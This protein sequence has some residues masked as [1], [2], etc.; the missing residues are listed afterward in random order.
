[1]KSTLLRRLRR[2]AKRNIYPATFNGMIVIIQKDFGDRYFRT[3]FRGWSV[4]STN[5]ENYNE[6]N[7]AKELKIARNYYIKGK[8]KAL[9]NQEILN[10]LNE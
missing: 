7:L 3:E 5:A 10:K 6:S 8:V 1:M 9:K 2:E 4:Y